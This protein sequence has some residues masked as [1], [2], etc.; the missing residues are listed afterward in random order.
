VRELEAA[1]GRAFVLGSVRP[2]E[3][4]AY[5]GEMESA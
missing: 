3:G 4:V 5:V 1:G 2:G